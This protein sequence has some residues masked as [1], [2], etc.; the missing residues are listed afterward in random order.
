[1]MHAG[2]RARTAPVRN[3]TDTVPNSDYEDADPAGGY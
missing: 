2:A 1:M 3:H